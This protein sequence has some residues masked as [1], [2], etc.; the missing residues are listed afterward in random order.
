[1]ERAKLIDSLD[2]L[3]AYDTGS[4]DSGIHDE[5]LRAECIAELKALPLESGEIYS[6]EL[7]RIVRDMWLTEDA[8]EDGYGLEE[9]LG[10][11]RW[12]DERMDGPIVASDLGRW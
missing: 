10:F 12:L 9:A 11:L 5:S 8:I 1:M 4:V 6:K 7:S 2:G 3:Y